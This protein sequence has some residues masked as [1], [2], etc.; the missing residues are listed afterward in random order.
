MAR[1]SKK[2]KKEVSIKIARDSLDNAKSYLED[3][4]KI[5]NSNPGH[6]YALGV[7]GIEELQKATIF[8]VLPRSTDFPMKLDKSLK[9]LFKNHKAKQFGQELTSSNRIFLELWDKYFKRTGVK[10]IDLM[11][12]LIKNPSDKKFKKIKEKVNKKLKVYENIENYKKIGMYVDF[13]N[14]KVVGPKDINKKLAKKLIKHLEEEINY[15][16]R[17]F[18]S[19]N[20][21]L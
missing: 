9:S 10:P 15:T 18:D 19:I 4:K 12:E 3:S 8:Y 14:G 13:I 17:L 11:K 21:F 5:L 2:L 20:K 6:A 16:E 1:C 7:L